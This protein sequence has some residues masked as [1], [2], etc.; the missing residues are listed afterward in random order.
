MTTGVFKLSGLRLTKLRLYV[1]HPCPPRLIDWPKYGNNGDDITAVAIA[2]IC[3]GFGGNWKI[4]VVAAVGVTTF[5]GWG[6]TGEFIVLNNGL[7]A[8]A[9]AAAVVRDGIKGLL[10]RIQFAESDA[11]KDDA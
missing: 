2:A 8:A 7:Q 1:W 9:A 5:C 6:A 10:D 4:G 3:W 11:D